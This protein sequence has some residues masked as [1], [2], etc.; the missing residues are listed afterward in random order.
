MSTYDLGC[1]VRR[2]YRRRIFGLAAFIAS[3]QSAKVRHYPAI[4]TDFTSICTSNYKEDFHQNQ[5]S[6]RAYSSREEER[7]VH[8]HCHQCCQCCEASENE[9]QTYKEFTERDN[10]VEQSCIWYREFFKEGCPPSLHCR[11]IT[12]C[13]FYSA[14]KEAPASNPPVNLPQPCVIQS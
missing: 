13:F 12:S 9:T 5:L 2:V 14:C 6:I 8:D 1:F 11:V 7:E 10:E 4:Q 3:D